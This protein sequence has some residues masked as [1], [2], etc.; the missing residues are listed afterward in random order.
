MIN[1][2]TYHMCTYN[3]KMNNLFIIIQIDKKNH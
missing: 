2:Y 3:S 1:D